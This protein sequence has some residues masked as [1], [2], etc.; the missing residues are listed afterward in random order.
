MSLRDYLP[1]KRRAPSSEEKATK[2]TRL[3]SDV[4]PVQSALKTTSTTLRGGARQT[5]VE[6]PDV[7]P[8]AVP[9]AVPPSPRPTLAEPDAAPQLLLGFKAS[10]V[11]SP[12]K[13]SQPPAYQRYASLAATGNVSYLPNQSKAA[14]QTKLDNDV[15]PAKPALKTLSTLSGGLTGV[16]KPD[17]QQQGRQQEP[18]IRPRSPQRVSAASSQLRA[19]RPSTVE[20]P[21]KNSQPPAYQRYA[22]LA[23]TVGNVS[24]LPN[25]SKAAKQVKLDNDVAPVKPALETLTATSGV[26]TNEKPD[27][28]QP[29]TPPGSPDRNPEASSPQLCRFRSFTVESPTKKRQLPAYQRYASL[30]ATGNLPIPIQYKVL[31]EKFRCSDT[32]VNMLQKRDEVCT[33]SKLK[34][35]VQDM[36]RRAFEQRN[37]AQMKTV[38]PTAFVFRQE[39]GLPGTYADVREKQLYQ[40]TV[41]CGGLGDRKCLDSATLVE[42]TQTFRN[43]LLKIVIDHHKL[44]LKARSPPIEIPDD[45]LIRWHPEFDLDNIP[46]V[47]EAELPKPPLTESY[48]TAKDVL[49]AAHDRFA[50]KLQRALANS[51]ATHTCDGE[52]GAPPAALGTPVAPPPP[53]CQVDPTLVG[54]SPLLLERIR[55]K[56]AA[57]ATAV[58]TRD[59]AV[60]KKLCMLEK[61]PD[62]CR[63]VKTFFVSEQKVAL[64]LDEV[65]A[66]VSESS[67]VSKESVEGH[68]RL[69]REVLPEWINLVTIRKRDYLK[70]NKNMD[71]KTII[72]ALEQKRKQVL[73]E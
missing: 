30:V 37:L 73:N 31:G 13:R 45:K 5:S 57:K 60:E 29:V 25:Q 7:Q 28:Q 33:L 68:V 65:V 17:L 4:T 23:A 2:K 21:T 36:M 24:S 58:M 19:L 26:R 9:P 12:K 38:Y 15:I 34:K 61:L 55:Q 49:A 56:E 27:V 18:V 43:G 50:A 59:P 62:I 22:S 20:S 52:T 46:D 42:R 11:E 51:S 66:K 54:I 72:N 53:P 1:I 71:I 69:L 44:F 10:V 64:F 35:A 47:E 40:L 39:K 8:P 16:E 48:T 63:I 32:V 70:I 6:K 3:D 41:E 14:E 67:G